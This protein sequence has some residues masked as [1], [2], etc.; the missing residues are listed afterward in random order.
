MN[1]DRARA[2]DRIGV[3]GEVHARGF[4]G[5]EPRRGTVVGEVVADLR[6]FPLRSAVRS[7]C[8]CVFRTG[9]LLRRH[10]ISQPTDHLGQVLRFGDGSGGRIY[11]ETVVQTA[12][13]DSPVVLVVG[14][15]LRWVRGRGHELFRAESL[16][17]TPLFVGFPGFVSKLWLA[18]DDNGVYRGFYQWNGLELADAY[19]RALWWVLALVSV[20][21]STRYVVLPALRRDDVL[22]DPTVLEGIAP[23]QRQAWWR[24]TALEQPRKR[25]QRSPPAEG[26]VVRGG[27]SYARCSPLGR[28]RPSRSGHSPRVMADRLGHASVGFTM[29]TSTPTE[30]PIRPA[31]EV[32]VPVL[33]K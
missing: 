4:G 12:A 11:R 32:A 21:G 18:H 2:A 14:F 6:P 5:S 15:R 23:G 8:G 9:A 27:R 31:D 26:K 3:S 13:V 16:L 17:N 22:T 1:D 10:A 33:E 28:E 19:V 25:R 29:D 20:R 30:R 24:L 7:L